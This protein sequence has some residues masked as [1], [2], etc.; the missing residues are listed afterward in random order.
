MKSITRNKKKD[1]LY[2]REGQNNTV[3]IYDIAVNSERNKGIGSEMISELKLQG[4]NIY[5]F[6]RESNANARRFYMKNNFT[7]I[8]IK[9][10]YP[11]ENAYM[12]LWLAQ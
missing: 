10:F 4:K 2:Y 12:A 1:Y 5:A 8:L 3:E 9:A 7:L 11:D 6:V